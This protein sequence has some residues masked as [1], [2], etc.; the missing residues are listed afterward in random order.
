MKIKEKNRD[1][2][3][4]SLPPKF[5]NQKMNEYL[6][7]TEEQLVDNEDS[8]VVRLMYEDGYPESMNVDF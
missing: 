2:T 8:T 3:V 5:Y 7:I 1:I 6:N 4:N